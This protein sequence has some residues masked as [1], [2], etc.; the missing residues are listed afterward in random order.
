MTL[1]IAMSSSPLRAAATEAA[2]SRQARSER[3]QGEADHELAD[4][5]VAGDFDA[6]PDQHP[7]ADE[8]KEQ[9]DRKERH[10][11]AAVHRVE[12]V[13]V[14]ES[15]SKHHS[16]ALRLVTALTADPRDQDEH[17]GQ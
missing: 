7:G 12:E 1:P 4:P 2:S 6:T 15:P 14:L 8:E 13:V 3:H 9:P 5:E 10:G 17:A 11:L 16:L